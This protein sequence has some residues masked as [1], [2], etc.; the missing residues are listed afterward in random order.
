MAL[1]QL[2]KS[3][4]K[5]LQNPSKK[6]SQKQIWSE[7]KTRKAKTHIESLL[8]FILAELYKIPKQEAEERLGDYRK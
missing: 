5:F 4:R 7:L 2:N 3:I 6:P 8:N 1:K